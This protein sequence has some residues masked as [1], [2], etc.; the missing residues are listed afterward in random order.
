MRTEISAVLVVFLI[1]SD[2]YA[3]FTDTFS[4]GNF[5]QSPV[6]SGDDVK[7]TV[8]AGRLKLQAQPVTS[9]AFL[10]TKSEAVH[11]ASW[12]FYLQMDFTPSSTN[13]AKVY[14]MSDQFNLT[15]G[16]NGYFVKIGGAT[17]DVSLYKQTGTA[18]TRII[19]GLDDRVNAAVVK[20]MIKVNR[21]T[22]GS[23]Q[24]LADAGL[25][26]NYQLE[27]TATDNTTTVASWFGVQCVYTSTRS[28]KFWFDDFVVTG[29]PVPVN[30]P[31]PVHAKDI[32]I[33]EIFPDP[34]P[35]LGLPAA[36]F[37]EL[38]NRSTVSI[39]LTGWKLTD[40][41]STAVLPAV[42][43]LP[44]DYCILTSTASSQLYAPFGKSIG[45]V[46]FPTLNNNGDL[47]QLIDAGNQT[48]DSV[49]FTLDWYRDADKAEGGWTL[50]LIDPMN[51]CGEEDN[52]SA[53]EA[54]A[55]GTPGHRNSVFAN[56]PDL[57][58]PEVVHVYPRGSDLLE[59]NFNEKLDP[60]MDVS[61]FQLTPS[62]SIAK[63][64]LSTGQRGVL[65]STAT[66][67][68]KQQRYTL[69]IQG[70]RDCNGNVIQPTVV[71]FGLPEA[72]DSLDLVINE[73]LFN[74]RPG[75]VDF[76]ELYNSSGKFVD[77]QPLSLAIETDG[78]L[79][80]ATVLFPDHHLMAPDSYAVFT[81]APDVVE[82]QYE[83][84]IGSNI[85]KSSL[86]T[87]R[88]DKGTVVIKDQHGRIID[89]VA[90]SD[91]WHS[92]FLKSVEGVSLERISPQ[93]PSNESINW[94]SAA[95]AAGF[96]T[97]GFANSQCRARSSW[98][99][100]VV[101]VDPPAFQPGDSHQEFVQIQYQLEGFGWVGNV[102][103]FDQE[104]H[105]VKTIASNETLPSEG[106]FVWHGDRDD[107]RKARLGYYVVWFE[108]FNSEGLVHAF[109]NR[110]AVVSR[111]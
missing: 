84:A 40:G 109:L 46:N 73:I 4:D 83:N 108:V 23:W 58:P 12:E 42:S 15:T 60:T 80:A 17:R 19:D 106:F 90:Y 32:L 34:S 48:I 30:T 87:L 94:T 39:D 26:G 85:H 97:P 33:N 62:T 102:R 54:V 22:N 2:C 93:G 101:R 103:I 41:S 86:P 11:L 59:I 96:A 5:T 69:L 91:Q 92:P 8:N 3:Q 43:M 56:R 89:R 52:W 100:G 45:L 104:C 64:A 7:F 61:C 111:D 70:I 99:Q 31:P 10:A 21:M 13:Y 71:D 57:S 82:G 27:G 50:E 66:P 79:K 25:T 53:S 107:G 110:V 77:L 18:E 20:I 88:D 81:N 75:G 55:G 37:V 38:Y 6:W 63:I 68:Y 24:L 1:A 47:V 95:A 105:P 74:P 67:L 78:I 51:P 65:L 98:V 14:V 16:L 72:A 29:T 76:V 28:D 44:G 49:Q 36:E 9:S 35:Q